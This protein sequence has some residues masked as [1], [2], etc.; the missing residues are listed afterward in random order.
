MNVGELFAAID[1]CEGGVMGWVLLRSGF[2]VWG[3]F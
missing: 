1:V 3:G 2:L